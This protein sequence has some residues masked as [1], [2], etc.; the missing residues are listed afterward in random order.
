M[1]PI[2]PTIILALLIVSLVLFVKS[3]MPNL[4]VEVSTTEESFAD[5]NAIPNVAFCPFNST[6]T[7]LQSGETHCCVGKT[8]KKFGCLEKT[9]CTLSASLDGKIPSCGS[10]MKKHYDEQA[11]KHCYPGLPKYYEKTDQYGNVTERGCYSGPTNISMSGPVST[12]Q[13][14]C[15]V[16][17]S[18][19]AKAKSDPKSCY[20]QKRLTA[21]QCPRGITCQKS[22]VQTGK[23]NPLLLQVSW[24]GKRKMFGG[25]IDA[26]VTT[27]TLSSI[28][29]YWNVVFP[30]WSK[31]MPLATTRA[32]SLGEFIYEIR[33]ALLEGK[34]APQDTTAFG[35]FYEA[36]KR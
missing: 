35:R 10:I 20:N 28:V 27:Y 1:S 36:P 22:F 2:V 32:D 11:K 8:S 31:A 30:E 4:Q 29:D 9:V 14:T 24:M 16:D 13:P 3:R 19:Q 6:A 33:K 5:K 12:Q 7:I 23:G 17:Y 15:V 18:S 34:I 21:V 26:P 25:D